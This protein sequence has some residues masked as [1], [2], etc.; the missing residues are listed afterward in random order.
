MNRQFSRNVSTKK[1]KKQFPRGSLRVT[2]GSL[3][4]AIIKKDLK[5]YCR[6]KVFIFLTVL[7]L[8][9]FVLIFWLMP[10]KVEESLII[11]FSPPLAVLVDESRAALDE[12]S[13]DREELAEL[14]A[15]DLSQGE[16]DGLVIVELEDEEQLGRVVEGRDE[17]YHTAAGYVVIGNTVGGRDIPA[18][19]RKVN[20]SIGIAFPEKFFAAAAR[21]EAATVTLYTRADVPLE[22][23]KAME[24]LVREMTYQIAGYELPVEFADEETIILGRDR[25]GQQVT[26]RERMRPMFAFFMLFMETLS[27]AALISTEVLQR[28][29]TALLV[30]PVRVSHFLAAKT[31]FGTILAFSQGLIIMILVGAFTPENWLLLLTTIFIG[32]LMFTGLAMI[33]GA[34]GK[35]FMGQLMTGMLFMIPLMIPA[36]AVFFPGTAATWV[37]LIPSYPVIDLL[38]GVTIYGVG[39]SD[40]F[41]A[42]SYA[43]VWVAVLY[44]AG[45]LILKRKVE[46]L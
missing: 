30:T 5:S 31:I 29:I 3:I 28:T 33:I 2:S 1:Q 24:S 42:L 26:M 13:Y 45:L 34:A 12:L 7:S 43:L 27:L 41:G 36:F 19:G 21:G 17:V 46:S 44:G 32:S 9:F 14:Y 10:D 18:G 38:A 37:Q 25:L 22:I 6:N 20:V 11:G 35:D 16:E 39:W 40:S 15:A 4:T 23:Q 8:V